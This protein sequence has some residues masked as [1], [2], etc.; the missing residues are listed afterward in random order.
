MQPSWSNMFINREKHFVM[1]AVYK[2]ATITWMHIFAS[3]VGTPDA[4]MVANSMNRSKISRKIWKYVK[5]MQNLKA[6]KRRSYLNHYYVAMI[7]RDPLVRLV[8]GYR[9][10]MVS[11][12]DIRNRIKRMFRRTV[13]RR[14]DHT[15]SLSTTLQKIEKSQLCK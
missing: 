14:F 1:C 11:M 4:I 6:A 10:K 9:D 12:P 7:V 15:P 8:S 3:L 13:S 2:A 5:L